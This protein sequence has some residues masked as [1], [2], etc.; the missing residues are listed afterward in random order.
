MSNELCA[1]LDGRVIDPMTP[2]DHDIFRLVPQGKQLRIEFVQ[3]RNIGFHRKF[4]ALLRV[5]IGYIDEPDRERMN[6]HNEA[7]LLN[8]LKIDLGLYELWIV[9][10]GAPLP[11]GT[12][13]FVPKSINFA[14]MDNTRF[15]R[16]YKDTINICIGQ[17]LRME[18]GNAL[19]RAV[20]HLLA[21]E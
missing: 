6:I 14:S 17:Y 10:E 7:E 19:D 20:T 5:I 3:Q 16:L 1:K 15:E 13:V 9:G 2:F 21:F 11:V 4:F 12:P 18:D 8:R